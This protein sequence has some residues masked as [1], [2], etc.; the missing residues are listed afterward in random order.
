MASTV[1]KIEATPLCA[2]ARLSALWV[3]W[4][5]S[6][7]SAGLPG[8]TVADRPANSLSGDVL[9]SAVS[10]VGARSISCR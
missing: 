6:A 1:K 2:V 4:T 7:T 5:A 3:P 8:A 9:P 10:A